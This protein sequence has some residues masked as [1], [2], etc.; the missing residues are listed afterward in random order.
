[1]AELMLS[2]RASGPNVSN[3]NFKKLLLYCIKKV[4]GSRSSGGVLKA[5]ERTKARPY[6]SVPDRFFSQNLSGTDK[7]LAPS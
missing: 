1:M 5:Q 4:P 2:S 7:A 3:R 6:L